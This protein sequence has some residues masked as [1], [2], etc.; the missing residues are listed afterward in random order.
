MAQEYVCGFGSLWWR[1]LNFIRQQK[2]SGE[3]LMKQLPVLLKTSFDMIADFNKKWQ[4][5][6]NCIFRFSIFM[7]ISMSEEIVQG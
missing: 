7:L 4:K 5:Q 3:P 6:R 1:Q 2:M